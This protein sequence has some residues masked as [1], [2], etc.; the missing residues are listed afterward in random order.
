MIDELKGI[1]I[2]MFK[3][4]DP[5]NQG[6][7]M[8]V[9][10]R[11][12]KN[13]EQ[14]LLFVSK[15]LG[16][17]RPDP[18]VHYGPVKT[19]HTMQGGALTSLRQLKDG[20]SY[21]AVLSG[22]HF[23]AIQYLV[24]EE[25][26][27]SRLV[28]GTGLGGGAG[29]IKLGLR[30]KVPGESLINLAPDGIVDKDDKPL[31]TSTSKG[32]KVII[33]LNGNDKVPDLKIVLNYRNCKSFERLLS[34]LSTIFQRRIRRIYDAHT[35]TRIK[36]LQQL[37]D[38]HNLVVG[39]EFDPLLKVKYPLVDPLT[40]PPKVKEHHIP[41]VVT[42]YPNGDAYHHG[43]QLTVMQKRYPT[44]K[45]LLTHLNHTIRLVN[46][47]ATKIFRLDNGQKIDESDP[48]PI[49]SVEPASPTKF[50]L[51]SGDDVFFNIRYDLNAVQKI[52]Y[53]E[54]VFE[55]EEPAPLVLME[56]NLPKSRKKSVVPK[57]EKPLKSKTPV[58]T[59]GNI[60]DPK[61]NKDQK[62][63]QGHKHSQNLRNH[64]ATLTQMKYWETMK[65]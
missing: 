14:F 35:Y 44:L 10:T 49:F 36:T 5:Y 37:H 55:E 9:T 16:S 24:P 54:A 62:R 47:R 29:L 13:Y 6:K 7:R 59:G 50:V 20:H 2:W 21:V 45:H 26:G 4:G 8:V 15:E 58:A 25:P 46:G 19:I 51:V 56:S 28:A 23:Q 38:G 34:T 31:F 43:F 65:Q 11:V 63:N 30:Q 3:N 60:N 48:S 64:T 41:K 1:R 53:G 40:A 22:D 42:F 17:A 52:T 57:K 18:N 27:K 12:Y 32:F 33:Y 39:T 61:L